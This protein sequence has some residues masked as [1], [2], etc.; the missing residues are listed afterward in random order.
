[1][2]NKTYTL[3]STD[4]LS[5]DSLFEV[6]RLA[7]S[8]NKSVVIPADLLNTVRNYITSLYY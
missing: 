8:Q 4:V 7:Y 2:N 6:L 1:M 3:D 5:R